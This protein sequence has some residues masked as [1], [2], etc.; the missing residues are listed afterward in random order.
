MSHRTW[1]KI[2]VDKWLEGTISEET[3]SVR[4]VWVS[5]LAL[6]GNGKYGDSGIIMALDGV[7]FNNNQLSAMLKITTNLWVVAKNRLEKTD[8]IKVHSNN[9]IEVVNWKKYQS[10]YE[11]TSKYRSNDTTHDMPIDTTHDTPIEGRGER[12]EGRTINKLIVGDNN[13]ITSYLLKLPRWGKSH[14]KEDKKWLSEFLID[15]PEFN[16]EFIKACRDYHS[17]KKSHSKGIWKTR[18]RNW[19]VKDRQYKANSKSQQEVA[20]EYKDSGIYKNYEEQE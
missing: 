1:I 10:E 4:G 13:S 8:R 5:L 2:Y 20:T 16:S 12:V 3:A 6:A 17:D 14:T 9:I 19:M 11:R 15:Y 7:G 18:L